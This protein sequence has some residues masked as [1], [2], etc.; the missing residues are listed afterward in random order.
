MLVE[1]LEREGKQV[2]FLREPGG[3]LISEKIRDILLDLRHAE[4]SAKSELFLFSAARNQLVTQVIQPALRQGTIVICDRFFDSTT[5]Y[6]GYGRGILLEEVKAINAIAVGGTVPDLTLF[7]TVPIEEILKR[8]AIKKGIDRM[9][10]SGIQFYER[11]HRGFHALAEQEPS[12]FAVI[13][14][15]PSIEEIHQTIWNILD[16]RFTISEPL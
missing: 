7:I 6:Q 12:R 15:T 9:E 16:R 5:A 2:I 8:Q 13:D 4:M 14:G 11:V 10:S 1:R 3:T